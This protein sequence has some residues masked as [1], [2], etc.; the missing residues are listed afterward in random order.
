MTVVLRCGSLIYQHVSR[1]CKPVEIGRAA[2]DG[3]LVE[4]LGGLTPTD[5]LIVGGRESL[6][7]G[8]RIRIA[9]EDTTMQLNSPSSSFG[10]P[11]T[12]RTAQAPTVEN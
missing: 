3:G 10:P 2:A 6:T 9:G 1:G 12:D 7:E 11:A 4:V 5:K 8:A